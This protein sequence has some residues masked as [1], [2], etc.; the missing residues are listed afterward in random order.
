M[1]APLSKP[2]KPKKPAAERLRDVLPEV[3]ALMKPRRWLLA[4]GL[5]LMA[6]NRVCG[7]VL[8]YSTKFLI[9]DVVTK[10]R[11]EMLL[12]LVSIVLLATLIQGVTSF[13]LTQLLSKA[14]QRMIAEL[15]QKVQWH[16]ARL[17]VAFYDANK[18]GT[19]VARIM[20]DV[21]G[22]RNLI[23]TGLVE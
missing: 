14:A 5:L 23:G 20:S 2:E 19:L 8:P 21:E 6:I 13:T 7:L 16:I 18:S 15:R 10:H 9:D 11:S 17:P 4:L 22:V 12:P 3:W 1:A